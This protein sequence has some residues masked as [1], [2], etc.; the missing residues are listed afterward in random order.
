MAKEKTDWC[1]LWFQDKQSVL[2]TMVK[3]LA[4]DLSAGYSYFGSSVTKQRKEIEAY[5]AKFNEEIDKV[6]SMDE[7]KASRWCRWDMKRRGVIE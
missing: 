1:E 2:E 3:N 5:K 7:G 6:S 4:A